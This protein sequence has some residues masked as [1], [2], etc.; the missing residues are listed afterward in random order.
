MLDF[1][2]QLLEISDLRVLGV[3]LILLEIV[4]LAKSLQH[5]LTM[6]NTLLNSLKC[7]ILD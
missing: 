5:L 1:L 4:L 6:I 7:L 3:V 2:N